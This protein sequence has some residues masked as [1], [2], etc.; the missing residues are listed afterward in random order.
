MRLKQKSLIVAIMIMLLMCLAGCGKR[1]VSLNEYIEISTDG[2]DSRGTATVSFDYRKFE[3]E[4]GENIKFSKKE[5]RRN[6]AKKYSLKSSTKDSE[7]LIE[8]CV[9]V[10][11]DKDTNLKNGESVSVEWD[12]DE[13]LAEKY[14]GVKLSYSDIEY[15]VDGLKKVDKFNP[16]DYI[17]VTFSGTSPEGKVKIEK[18]D[19]RKE[20]KDVSFEADKSS[21]L[22]IGDVV[23]VKATTHLSEAEFIELYGSLISETE[24]QYTC[25]GLDYY[26]TKAQVPSANTIMF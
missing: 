10:G 22:E 5:N 15:K 19:N 23:K 20:L 2:Y 25:E 8:T 4:N 24:K 1:T 26:V 6:F 9:K 14:F 12:C 18:D 17:K 11:L 7:L 13:E 16:F 21:N 3:R